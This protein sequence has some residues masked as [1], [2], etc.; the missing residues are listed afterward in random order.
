M[1]KIELNKK[2]ILITGA[3]GFIGSNL[4]KRLLNETTGIKIIGIDNLNDYYDVSIK[5]YRLKQ[6]E[7]ISGK[8]NLAEGEEVRIVLPWHILCADGD[9]KRNNRFPWHLQ[10]WNRQEI[11]LR[12]QSIHCFLSE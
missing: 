5:E 11:R 3:A 10:L 12:Y 4:V 1:Q 9:G 7:E 2:A 6:L 8:K